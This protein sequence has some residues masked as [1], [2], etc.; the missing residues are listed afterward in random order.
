MHILEIRLSN[1]KFELHP[2]TLSVG[3][4]IVFSGFDYEGNKESCPFLSNM[5]KKE[6]VMCRR[7]TR[8]T[9]V[10]CSVDY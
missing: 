2:F 1:L 7:Y 3:R 6:S 5:A 10:A 9:V 8:T 4:F